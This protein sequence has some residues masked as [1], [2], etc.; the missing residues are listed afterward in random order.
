MAMI[1]RHY[2]THQRSP[3]EIDRFTKLGGIDWVA[4]SGD[5]SLVPHHCKKLDQFLVVYHEN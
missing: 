5:K 1:L 3:Y 4:P 2:L